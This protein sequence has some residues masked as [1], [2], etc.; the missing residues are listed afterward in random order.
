NRPGGRFWSQASPPRLR[1]SSPSFSQGVSPS[2]ASSPAAW[3][4]FLQACPAGGSESGARKVRRARNSKARRGLT[5]RA[6][7]IRSFP[8]NRP[9]LV[10]RIALETVLALAKLLAVLSRLPIDPFRQP[11]Q[12]GLSTPRAGPVTRSPL[13]ISKI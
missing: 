2:A 3:C 11:D 1:W 8:A 4:R 7:V 12:V 13:V 5:Q 6:E 10:P 9:E